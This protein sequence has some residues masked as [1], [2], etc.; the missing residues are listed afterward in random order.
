MGIQREFT[1]RYTSKQNDVAERRNQ[2]IIEATRENVGREEHA[3]IL[4]GIE[5]TRENVGR[6]EHARILL[7]RWHGMAP[8]VFEPKTLRYMA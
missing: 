1:C 6:E 3:R 8:K 5:E 7:G 2:S 4:L